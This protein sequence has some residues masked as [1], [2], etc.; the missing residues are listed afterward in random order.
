M[1]TLD[2]PKVEP[3]LKWTKIELEET[4]DEVSGIS[5]PHR[6]LRKESYFSS[7][8]PSSVSSMQDSISRVF[9][10]GKGKTVS[11]VTISGPNPSSSRRP[12]GQ[13]VKTYRKYSSEQFSSSS[14]LVEKENMK[15]YWLGSGSDALDSVG[16]STDIDSGDTS[17]NSSSGIDSGDSGDSGSNSK[18]TGSSGDST[19]NDSTDDSTR[20][21]SSSFEDHTYQ[22]VQQI[23]TKAHLI[24]KWI[25]SQSGIQSPNHC[26][27][28]MIPTN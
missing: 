4:E 1:N 2:K 26:R 25:Q 11:R 28:N 13:R 6:I 5:G 16:D 17:L 19:G 23:L 7:E 21:S 18:E 8:N 15:I 27:G 12:A 24:E 22:N 9:G 3:L 14:S 20:N 10:T